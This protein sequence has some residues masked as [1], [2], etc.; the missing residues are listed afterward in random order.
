MISF[1]ASRSHTQILTK[2]EWLP[3][4]ITIIPLYKLQGLM[5]EQREPDFLTEWLYSKHRNFIYDDITTKVQN[6]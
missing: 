5:N 4:E 2:V 6:S 3:K 1:E